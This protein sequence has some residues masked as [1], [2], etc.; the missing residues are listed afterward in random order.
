MTNK[1][2]LELE[3]AELILIG[4]ALEQLPYVVVKPFIDKMQAQISPQLIKVATD[5]AAQLAAAT[6]EPTNDN[7]PNNAASDAGYPAM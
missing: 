6:Q 1:L 3:H 5:A 4:K 2:I 7:P